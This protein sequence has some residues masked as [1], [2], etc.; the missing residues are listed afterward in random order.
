[1]RIGQIIFVYIKYLDYRILEFKEWKV[2]FEI[3]YSIPFSLQMRKPKL[4]VSK[5]IAHDHSVY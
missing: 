1:M 5:C 2:F 3:V 4:R